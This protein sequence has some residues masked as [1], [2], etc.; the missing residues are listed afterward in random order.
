[1]RGLGVPIGVPNTVPPKRTPYDTRSRRLLVGAG[2]QPPTL[3]PLSDAA[4]VEGEILGIGDG[5]SARGGGPDHGCVIGAQLR[6]RDD[7]AGSY[8]RAS[9][10]EG[11]A[12]EGVGGN[13]ACHDNGGRVVEI[14]GPKELA[15]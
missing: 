15:G 14:Q 4:G 9:F 10:F 13:A 11:T 1:M 12:Q 8:L 3:E 6:W 2:P 7:E 5:A